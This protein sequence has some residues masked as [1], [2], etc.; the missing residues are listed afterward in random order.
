MN[1]KLSEY[2]VDSSLSNRDKKPIRKLIDSV[3]I[4]ATGVGLGAAASAFSALKKIK[5]ETKLYDV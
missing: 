3:A 4:P 5:R 1:E 2:E